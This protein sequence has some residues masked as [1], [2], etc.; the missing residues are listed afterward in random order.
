M[1]FEVG[2]A[3]IF[4]AVDDSRFVSVFGVASRTDHTLTTTG[5]K[6]YNIIHT[7]GQDEHLAIAGAM[8]IAEPLMI[9]Y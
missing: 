4:V 5:C 7:D 1:R 3:Y 9:D 2:K 8:A 6:T